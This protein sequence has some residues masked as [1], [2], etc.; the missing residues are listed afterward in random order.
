M[1]KTLLESKSARREV[2]ARAEQALGR[3]RV[4][5]AD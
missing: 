3:V 4:D 2:L 5:A 1:L